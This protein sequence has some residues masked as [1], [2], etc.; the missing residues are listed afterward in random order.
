MRRA[1]GRESPKRVCHPVYP[2]GPIPAN[3]SAGPW[4][5]TN[6][7]RW[8]RDSPALTPPGQPKNA[9][10]FYS[11][12]MLQTNSTAVLKRL[13]KQEAAWSSMAK[14]IEFA[15]MTLGDFLSHNLELQAAVENL[16]KHKALVRGGI[17]ARHEA[18]KKA[19]LMSK[20]L[21]KAIA[22]HPAF[23]EDSQLLRASGFKTESEIK[24]GRRSAASKA[25]DDNSDQR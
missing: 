23:G 22:S 1:S 20:R 16:D 11:T 18:E 6:Q 17:K 14:D 4:T 5:R 2:G 8:P 7:P 10:Q 9:V 13:R 12:N 25:T 21:A 19:M 15:G 3:Y 24:R